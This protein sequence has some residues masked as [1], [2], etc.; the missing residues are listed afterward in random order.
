MEKMLAVIVGDESRAYEVSHVLKQLDDEGS[1]EIYAEAVVARNV[2]GSVEVKRSEQEFPI[3]GVAGAAIGALVGILGGAVGFGIGGI[4]GG[5]AGSIRDFFTAEV[6]AE[7]VDEVCA[8]LTAGRFAVIADIDEEW[9]AP[10]DTR[11]EAVG[12]IVLRTPRVN[13]E[14]GHRTKAIASL[15]AEVAQFESELARESSGRREK[16][17]TVGDKLK[18]RLELNIAEVARRM[19]ETR[20]ETDA[21]IRTLRGKAA[22]ARA[23]V[24]ARLENRIQQIRKEYR[25][26]R[27][28]LRRILA[29][30]VKGSAQ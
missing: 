27:A 25:Q 28:K 26:S 1:I 3:G 30:Q 9:V 10:L 7:F 8:A 17:R 19:D 23:D 24:K 13:F 22:T 2:D 5:L 4:A 15:R 21:K 11:L 6:S 14:E 16:L 20:S 12:G 18:A 29:G